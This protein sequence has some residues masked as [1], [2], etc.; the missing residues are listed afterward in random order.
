M[1]L[2]LVLFDKNKGKV[3]V[4]KILIYRVDFHNWATAS[5][6]KFTYTSMF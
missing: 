3:L 5:S 6:L 4:R 1:T 2:V